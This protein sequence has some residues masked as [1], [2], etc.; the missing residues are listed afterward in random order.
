[1]TLEDYLLNEAGQPYQN[2]SEKENAMRVIGPINKRQSPEDFI[3]NNP[4]LKTYADNLNK[5]IIANAERQKQDNINSQI[6]NSVSF[7]PTGLANTVIS[8]SPEILTANANVGY[9]NV[10]SKINTQAALD[11]Y[12]NRRGNSPLQAVTVGA[13]L[14]KNIGPA[15]VGLRGNA[16]LDTDNSTVGYNVN[17]PI[18]DSNINY[19]ANTIRGTGIPTQHVSKLGLDSKD[20]AG[21]NGLAASMVKESSQYND[22][23]K[24]V[25]ELM[26]L[27]YSPNKDITFFANKNKLKVDGDVVN[28][29]N[30]IGAEYKINDNGTISLTRTADDS[31]NDGKPQLGISGSYRF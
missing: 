1:M 5:N 15:T 25:K 26:N 23:P 28:K 19:E 12:F 20:I 24:E 9:G 31:I 17:V 27:Q 6:K 3:A 21:I 2:K 16:Q 4:A 22:N 10:Y 18:S 11:N 13:D 30:Q 14:S 7:R 8:E 29:G